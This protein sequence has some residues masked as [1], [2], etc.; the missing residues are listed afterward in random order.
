M[1]RYKDSNADF[2]GAYQVA[3]LIVDAGGDSG[4]TRTLGTTASRSVVP[5]GLMNA[6]KKSAIFKQALSEWRDGLMRKGQ[7]S[8]KQLWLPAIPK[9]R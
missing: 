4:I 5:G 6:K 1:A 2:Y 7:S 3:R 8:V 9:Q